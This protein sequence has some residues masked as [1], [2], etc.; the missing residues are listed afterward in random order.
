MERMHYEVFVAHIK[1]RKEN[2]PL[3]AKLHIAFPL[4]PYIILLQFQSKVVWTV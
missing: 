2:V 3:L 4:H 1:E